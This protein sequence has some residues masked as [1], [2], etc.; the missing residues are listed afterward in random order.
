MSAGP[1][2]FLF[3]GVDYKKSYLLT[4]IH[5]E[6]RFRT[7]DLCIIIGRLHGTIVGPTGRPHPG[8]VRMVSQTSRTDRTAHNPHICQSNQ[9]G[10]L[11]D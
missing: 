7:R 2:D 1:S 8:Y 3:L 5:T 4:Y 6:I 10:L 9:C 11:A